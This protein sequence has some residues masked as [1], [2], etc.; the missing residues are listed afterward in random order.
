MVRCVL[1][2][3]FRVRRADLG[4]GRPTILCDYPASEAALAKLTR[5][6]PRIAERF[7]LY[8]CGVELANAF[9]ELTDADEQRR[10]FAEDMAL[11]AEIYGEAYPIDEDFLEALE[12][13]ARGERR[14]ARF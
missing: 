3:A 14:G 10:R 12:E 8:A 11:K 6:D 2:A 9:G 7:E 5:D 13:H 4:L 1:A